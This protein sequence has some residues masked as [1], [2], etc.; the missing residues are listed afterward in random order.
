M[1]ALIPVLLLAGCANEANH[2]GNPL[3]LPVSGLSTLVEN[4][5]YGA[6]RADVKAEVARH[7]P[8]LLTDPVAQAALWRVAPVAPSDRANVLRD[9]NDLPDPGSAAWIEAA[10]VAIMVRL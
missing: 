6:R 4:A 5:A 7:G 1:R 3:L 8:A 9:I 2:L 10:T